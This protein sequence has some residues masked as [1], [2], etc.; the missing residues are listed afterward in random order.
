ML[1][2]NVSGG[3]VNRV[4]PI[5]TVRRLENK[6][7]KWEKVRQDRKELPGLD[8]LTDRHVSLKLK[9]KIVNTL[10]TFYVK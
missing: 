7:K 9:L 10:S 1:F 2:N 8:P 5:L 3:L 4:L 6:Q